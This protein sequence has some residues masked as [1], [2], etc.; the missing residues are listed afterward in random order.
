MNISR[1]EL[2]KYRIRSGKYDDMEIKLVSLER[3]GAVVTYDVPVG[4]F[5]V[6]IRLLNVWLDE[7]QTPARQPLASGAF[8]EVLIDSTSSVAEFIVKKVPFQT[9]LQVCR[10]NIHG[11]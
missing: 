4:H 1:V 8:G 2:S 7:V 9:T 10:Q 5:I 11:C 6:G 3:K